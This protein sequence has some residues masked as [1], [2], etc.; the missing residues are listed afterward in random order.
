M[1]SSSNEKLLPEHVLQS[2]QVL[3]R[4]V[5]R[6]MGRLER[7]D[8]CNEID[9]IFAHL[10]TASTSMVGY[11]RALRD[12]IANGFDEQAALWEEQELQ[13]MKEASKANALFWRRDHVPEGNDGQDSEDSDDDDDSFVSANENTSEDGDGSNDQ[14]EFQGD[15]LLSQL[16]LSLLPTPVQ[17]APSLEATLLKL[18][19]Q[20]L[21]EYSQEVYIPPMAKSSLQA[22]NDTIFPLMER[23]QEFLAGDD[24]VFLIVGDSG[25]GKSSF[26]RQLEHNLWQEYQPG[27]VI[28]LFINLPAIDRPAENLIDKQ[29]QAY[30]FSDDEI[31]ELK[32][33]GHFILICDGYDESRLRI[34]IHTTNQLNRPDEWRAKMIIS[35]RTQYLGSDYTSRFMP[36]SDSRYRGPKPGLL[37]E[38]VVAPFSKDQIEIYVERYVPLEPRAWTKNDY[39]DK[40]KK[41]PNMMDLVKNPF[42]L[43]LALEALPSVAGEEQDSST[44]NITRVKLY[45]TFVSHWLSVN[46]RRLQAIRMSEEDSKVLEI[47]IDNGFASM[48]IVYST[49]LALAIFKEQDGNPVVQYSHLKDRGTWKADFFGPDPEVRLLRESSPLS[50][51][52]NLFQFVH[53]SILE[54]FFSCAVF[55]P[56]A[57]NEEGEL[58]PQAGLSPADEPLS[59]ADHPLSLISL[60]GEPS[61]VQFLCDRVRQSPSFK[62]QLLTIVERSKTDP[63]AS[64]AA[65]NAVTILFKSGVR[66]RDFKLRDVRIPGADLSGG[67]L[68]SAQLQGADLTG[69]N[70]SRSWLRQT[71]FSNAMM[72]G[73][74]FG[75]WPYLNVDKEPT[76]CAYSAD[77]NLLAVGLSEG[78]IIIYDTATWT[79]TRTLAGHT[80]AVTGL[81][82]SPR[83]RLRLFSASRD[84]TWGDWDLNTGKPELVPGGHGGVVTSIAVSLDGQQLATGGA[85]NKV[86]LWN[87]DTLQQS[88]LLQGHSDGVACLAFSPDG[89]MLASGSNDNTVRLWDTMSGDSRSILQGHSNIIS[90]IAFAPNGQQIVSGSHDTTV[91]IWSVSSGELLAV[92]HGHT[93]RV[94]AAAYSPHGQH[95]VS[96]SW[97]RTVRVWDSETHAQVSVLRGATRIITSLSVSPK[98][99][100]QVAACSNDK[101]VRLWDATPSPSDIFSNG[102]L[103]AGAGLDGHIAGVSTIAISYDGQQLATGGFDTTIRTHN[104]STGDSLGPPLCAHTRSV[105]AVAFSPSGQVLASASWD[106]T[107]RLWDTERREQSEVIRGHEAIVTSLAFLPSG[108]LVSCSADW[109]ICLWDVASRSVVR[110]FKGHTDAVRSVAS[111]SDGSRMVSGSEDNTVRIWNVHSGGTETVFEGHTD[112]VACVAYS[113]NDDQIASASED[114]TIRLWSTT[115]SVSE[116][117][118]LTRHRGEVQ[119]VAYSPCGGLIASGS[120]DNT[121]IVW[122]ASSG[123]LL[124]VIGDVFGGI[125]SVVWKPDVLDFFV[126]CKDGS[127]R[128]W[129]LLGEGDK[130]QVQLKW[131]TG[132]GHLVAS[133]ARIAG[134]EGL[135]NVAR[136][137]LIQRGADEEL[138]TQ[139]SESMSE[140]EEQ[141]PIVVLQD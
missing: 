50:R 40:L 45:D 98:G 122:D 105:A 114:K 8:M 82:F 11:D 108:Q 113:P 59:V 121:V 100:Q 76:A 93:D 96:T 67:E 15:N 42:L 77:G 99:L 125:S 110:V 81:A 2:T 47:L 58:Y 130:A 4:V 104:A 63:E 112:A 46:M 94:S 126:G 128:A 129:M 32:Q 26:N 14:V 9:A 30:N 20:T 132:F 85:D 97:D 33:N 135:S 74:Q 83:A 25:S 56:N 35:C 88:G 39:M 18:R 64:Q 133:K 65:A 48:G 21:S 109:T 27:G 136:A 107:I 16:H 103:L 127:I 101:T 90:G 131:G 61:I 3:Q 95:I 5:R 92:L 57:Y 41:I 10:D 55:K 37:Q 138:F 75:E 34:N 60:N 141:K 117:I 79:R 49:K 6:T 53:R 134:V 66:L 17:E 29:L 123:T 119:C 111:S 28:P 38:A 140:V 118:V 13:A 115:S 124:E 31:Q 54:Y 120:E 116:P 7:I 12:R 68:D 44:I 84:E 62:L 139:C 69:V 137:L 72:S 71:D 70:F 52:G 78:V 36:Q 87:C 89:S 106:H 22:S 91:R 24:E 51:S 86:K 23:V 1:A 43:S 80:K 73:V 102:I 19:S